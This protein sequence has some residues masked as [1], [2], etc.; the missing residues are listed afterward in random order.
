[1]KKL[2]TNYT[3]NKT[4]KT[5][6]LNDYTE[7]LQ[8]GLLLITN[9][10]DNI[11]IYNFASSSLGG[12]VS[13]NTLTLTYDTSSMSNTDSLQIFYDDGFVASNSKDDDNLNLVI[14]EL[15]QQAAIDPIWYDVATNALRITGAVTVTGTLTTVS[16]VTTVS[17]LTNIGGVSADLLTENI[18]ET[19]WGVTTRSILYFA[20]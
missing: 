20:P 16:T 2:E 3:F 4:A 17:G 19:D 13:G 12:T 1:M 18:M 14:K 5:V 7:I 11:V 9:V 6:T 15:L 8:N 10:T